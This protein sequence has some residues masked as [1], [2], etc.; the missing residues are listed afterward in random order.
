MEEARRMVRLESFLVGLENFFAEP[1]KVDRAR[2]E[3]LHQKKQ[4]FDNACTAHSGGNDDV[5][6]FIALLFI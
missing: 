3:E 6:I 5:R 2:F 1:E 4:A